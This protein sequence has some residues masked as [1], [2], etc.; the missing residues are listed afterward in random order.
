MSL[1]KLDAM[2]P[3]QELSGSKV[4]NTACAICLEE[5]QPQDQVRILPCAHGFCAGCID[6][7]LTKKST[8]C[9]VCKYDCDPQENGSK[10]SF[11]SIPG[12]EGLSSSVVQQQQQQEASNVAEGSSTIAPSSPITRPLPVHLQNGP[13]SSMNT[14]PAA[15]GRFS[16]SS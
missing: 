11:S 16:S 6:V 9:P 13:T 14:H 15:A 2:C 1:E 3:V 5:L 7:W 8:L 4:R 12:E 10:V